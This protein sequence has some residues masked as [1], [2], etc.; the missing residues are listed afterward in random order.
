M[1]KILVNE[2]WELE[3]DRLIVSM[4]T[5][6]MTLCYNC[7]AKMWVNIS[8]VSLALGENLS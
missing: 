4:V 5:E 7:T 2:I 6:T 1:N 8:Q 3:G